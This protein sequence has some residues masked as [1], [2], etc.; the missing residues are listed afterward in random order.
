MPKAHHKTQKDQQEVNTMMQEFAKVLKDRQITK[1]KRKRTNRSTYEV[2][3]VGDDFRQ[4]TMRAADDDS[5]ASAD[6]PDI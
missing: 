1:K 5:D 6:G 2:F 4:L 3:N